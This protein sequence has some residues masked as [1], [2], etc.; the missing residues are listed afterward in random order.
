VDLLAPTGLALS[1]LA[2]PLIA[3]YFLR[4]RRRRVRVS[5]LLPWHALAQSDRLA[6]P[7]HRFRRHLLLLLQL[8]ILLLIALA[9]ARPAVRSEHLGAQSIVLVVDT[10]ASMGAV[11]ETPHRLGAAV[12]L[13]QDALDGLGPADE[14]MLVDAGPQTRVTVPFTHDKGRV[15]DALKRLQP[16]E[17]EGS[18]TSGVQLALSVARSRPNVEVVVLSDGGGGDLA[19][20]V[21]GTAK[22]RFARVGTQTTNAG[23]LA[24]DLR[25]SPINDLDRQLFLTVQ[26]FGAQP[27]EATIEVYIEGALLG[28]R[29]QTLPPGEPVPLVFDIPGAARGTLRVDLIA[30][31]DLLAAD[32]TAFAVL[33]EPS[34][35]RVLLV[36]E[37]P[38]TARALQ[39]DPRVSLVRARASD[40]DAALLDTVDCVLFAGAVSDLARGIPHAVLGPHPGTPLTLGDAAAAPQVLDWQRTHPVLRFVDMNSV[41]IGRT[42]TVIAPGGL[43]PLVT[44]DLGPLV[45]GGERHG[46]RVV[47]LAFDPYWSDLPLRVGWPVFVL[48]TVGWLTEG[49][50]GG[51]T[52]LA[53]T[54]QP[55]LRRV[56]DETVTEAQ[57]TGPD[58][59][60]T[61]P[62][63]D[64]VVRLTQTGRVGLYRVRAGALNTSFAANLL[65][66]RESQIAPRA[67][68]DFGE[69]P[70]AA[71][72]ASV[73]TGRRE[74]WRA[75]LLLAL[76]FLVLEWW[77]WNRRSTA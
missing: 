41:T 73:V 50:S 2:A 65:S 49:A 69:H 16:A 63:L 53:K 67:S 26:N 8:L 33:T 35:R 34:A 61:V 27:N 60:E 71:A 38:L 55:W 39:A 68:L 6:S 12:A 70:A 43:T 25:R 18:L 45:L 15:V 21:Q 1:A 76:V 77:A 22:V 13:A 19:G 37:D 72:E 29:N 54:G 4:I 7:F 47:A 62:L 32:N 14:V 36:G 28:L 10:S 31:R 5:S 56:A 74:I 17:A 57:I 23:I 30:E 3:L 58:G 9:L 51:E 46:G 52:Q 59:T 40:V 11:D 24:L 42:R 66:E 48:N 44:S 64:G 20:L 75:L